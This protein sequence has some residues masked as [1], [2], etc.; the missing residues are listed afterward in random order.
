VR[1]APAVSCAMCT[2]RCAHEHTGP[3]ENTRLSL[4]NGFTAYIMVV[5]VRRALLPPSPRRNEPAQ[6]DASIRAPDHTT[7]PSA[8]ATFVFV[9]SAA[10]ASHRNVRDDG[11]RP[12]TGETGGVVRVICPTAQE[13]Y[14]CFSGL[15]RFRKIRSDLPVVVICA[16][17]LRDCA[18]VRGDAVTVI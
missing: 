7:S 17:G 10:T 2:K 1:A 11:R 15:T 3:A 9:T 14:F 6:L 13:E 16:R 8:S 18:C 12:L 4:R 5:L